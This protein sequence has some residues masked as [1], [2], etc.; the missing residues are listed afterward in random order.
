MKKT[1]TLVLALAGAVALADEYYVDAVF[2]NDDWDGSSSNH[3]SELV[4]PKRTLAGVIGLATKEGD[5]I[6]ALPGDYAEKTMS[7]GV[8]R[9]Y[10]AGSGIR[11]RSTDGWQKTRIVG[12]HGSNAD[13]TG[14]GAIRCIEVAVG[15]GFILD[16]FT[17][18]NGSVRSNA[19][20]PDNYGGGVYARG[21][22][23]AGSFTLVNCVVSNC[24]AYRGAGVYGGTALASRLVGNVGI[25]FASAAQYA[26]LAHCVIANNGGKHALSSNIRLVNCTVFGNSADFG[27]TS[28][29]KAYNSLLFHQTATGHAQVSLYSCVTDS[30]NDFAA[31]DAACA[32]DAGEVH[33][34]SPFTGDLRLVSTS[35]AAEKG[36]RSYL[37]LI[38]WPEGFT[39][40]DVDGVPIP[41][42]GSLAAGARQ[43]VVT[44]G[45]SRVVFGNAS[46]YTVEIDGIDHV[47]EPG[48]WFYPETFPCAYRAKATY[49][50]AS[51]RVYAYYFDEY[52]DGARAIHFVPQY[53]GWISFLPQPDPTLTTTLNVREAVG[54]VYYANSYVGDDGYD[55]SSPTVGTGS[56]GPKKTLQAAVGLCASNYALVYATGVFDEGGA[57]NGYG[58]SNR[59]SLANNVALVA[60][61]E[62]GAATIVGAPSP[63][64]GGLGAN[65]VGGV[66]NS[67][68]YSYVQG[69]VIQGC[70]T[71]DSTAGACR[72]AALRSSEVGAMLVDCTVRDNHARYASATFGGRAVRTRFIGNESDA[73]VVNNTHCSSC[74]FYGNTYTTDS[75]SGTCLYGEEGKVS[76][77]NCTIVPGVR[78]LVS[79]SGTTPVEN[80]LLTPVASS[81]EREGFQ[82]TLVLDE[83]YF[84]A[85]DEGDFRLG[86]LSEAI[87]GV[88]AGSFGTK[89]AWLSPASDLLGEPFKF[90]DGRVTVGAVHNAPGL[91]MCCIVDPDGPMTASVV[92]SS[93][94]V[95]LVADPHRPLIAYQVNDFVITNMTRTFS[96]MPSAEPGVVTTVSPIYG[97]DWYVNPESGDDDNAGGTPAAA[98]RTPNAALE[99]ASAG[100]SVLLAPGVYG[101]A[102][103]SAEP[104]SGCSVASRIKVPADVTVAPA[105]PSAETVIEGGEMIRCAYLGRRAKLVGLTLRGARGSEGKGDDGYGAAAF[106]EAGSS[107][108][109]MARLENC[110]I[111]DNAAYG[112]AL[113]GCEL[114]RCRILGNEGYV[115]SP[116]G[117]NCAYYGCY[118]NGN[119][120]AKLVD[121]YY[122]FDSCTVGPDNVPA[123]GEETSVFAA[124]NAPLLNSLI[125]LA[126]SIAK[127]IVLTNCAYRTSRYSGTSAVNCVVAD[128]FPADEEGRPIIGEND[129]V[130]A[131]DASLTEARFVSDADLTGVQRVYNGAQDIG[132]FE[133]DW[134]ETYARALKSGGSLSVSA[135]SPSVTR[136][137]A[138]SVGLKDGSS[139]K[140]TWSG[141][142]AAPAVL[143][144]KATLTGDGVLT[145]LV[146]G[147]AV[148][149]L[150]AAGIN[151]AKID[152][153]SATDEI[154]FTFAGTGTADLALPSQSGFIFKI[155]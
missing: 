110:V 6:W 26:D 33:A 5:T 49:A 152:V 66:W 4:G 105:D 35:V 13:G 155:Q 108:A 144:V 104:P 92:R 54:G 95:E 133:A 135:A 12:A 99:V 89:N 138:R 126:Y 137:S 82:N 128:E 44:P 86:V 91:A 134:R 10:V 97:T 115:R 131:G 17:V 71:A 16:G 27:G 143:N 80:C 96:F 11:L 67:S 59:V 127:S 43:T 142:A 136:A 81:Q 101:E 30:A 88:P 29:I 52:L 57:D 36:N 2:G 64:T 61:G 18:C 48:E 151:F 73:Y 148:R 109:D 24:V 37:S 153:A 41:A 20:D 149:T 145:V 150:E 87:G 141:A 120:G 58:F 106:C 102:L 3:V 60:A 119:V 39:P 45:A 111:S 74:V 32:L 98:L 55:G 46:G 22:A 121:R 79:Q 100:S 63:E 122:G 31:A 34:M 14:P 140:A 7:D 42:T 70:Y 129:A 8:N 75:A 124:A 85:A 23:D 154:A 69:F 103:G 53:D 113:W 56:V 40:T 50:K 62:P 118:V 146:N 1:L 123:S 15:A 19:K 78:N 65:A 21:K 132:A 51:R 94:P 38:A 77:W 76:A 116:V 114:V 83:P 72:G 9:L 125:D 68:K 28:A 117:A 90:A 130:D 139:L 47:F 112:G 147:T 107:V 84:A 93:E 25:S